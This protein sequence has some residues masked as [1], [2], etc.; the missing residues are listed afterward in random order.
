[1]SNPSLFHRVALSFSGLGLALLLLATASVT[2]A[3]ALDGASTSLK[4]EV[5]VADTPM[6][7]DLAAQA[8]RFKDSPVLKPVI[9][10]FKPQALANLNWGADAV[11][12]FAGGEK[13]KVL[14]LIHGVAMRLPYNSLLAVAKLPEIAWISPDRQLAAVWDQDVEALGADQ[15]WT[16]VRSPGNVN[17]DGNGIGVAILDSG[18]DHTHPDFSGN[19]GPRVIAFHDFV[20][21][22]AM[23]YDDNGHGTHVAGIVAGNGSSSN[24]LFQGVAPK[25]NLIALKVLD[26][27]GRGTASAVLSALDW[28]VQ[29]K[30]FFGIRV[31]NLSLGH[32]VVESNVTDPLCVAVR[33]CVQAGLVVV[34][35]AGNKGKNL[36]GTLVYGGISTPGNDPSVITVGAANTLETVPRSN[37]VV[38]TY[39]SRGPTAINQFAK[40]DVVAPG[41]K[42]VSLRSVGS[43]LDNNYPGNRVP[44]YADYFLL[45]GTSMAAPQVAGAAALML[46]ANPNL[47]VNAV[48]GILMFTAQDIHPRDSQGNEL[49]PGLKSLTQG[50]GA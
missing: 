43:Y 25:A 32:D 24:L 19:S 26:H 37:D 31:L 39:S 46:Q 10:R 38:T 11:A 35:S 13:R 5:A 44:G 4:T 33:A 15:A 36:Q 12:G 30:S 7:S 49:H 28:C 6:S 48:K 45:S 9:V 20:N 16:S 1:M 2:P 29:N 42:I 40:P 34:C 41:N 50:A 23:P 22:Y 14:P 8:V 27:Q 21:S 17:T 18:V 47:S 3:V